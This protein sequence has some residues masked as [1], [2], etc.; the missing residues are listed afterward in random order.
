[1]KQLN[2][3]LSAN[4]ISLKVNVEKTELVIFKYPRKVLSDEI[5]IKLTGK[6]L[7]PSNSVKYLGVRIDKFLHRHDQV[8]NIAVKLNRANA[9]LLKIRNY[10]NMKTLRNIYYAIFDSHLTYSWTVWA[11]NI[12]TVNRLIIL[13]KKA[14]RIMNFKDQLFHPS[15]LFSENN[16]LKFTDKITLGNILFVNKSINRRVP[17]IFYDWFTF[18]GDLQR[19]ETCWFVTNHLN[20]PTFRTKKYGRF[21]TRAGTIYSWNSMQNLLIKNLSLK[22]S[23]S[24]KIKY[25]LTKLF[26]EKY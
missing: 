2:N 15:P 5:K 21:S 14:L 8:N 12:K 18:S 11:P 4:K 6:R 13:Q 25:F 26:I 19:Y 23:T 3:W 17:P 9:L 7:Y 22:N 1:M 24:K 10:V 20:I 16:I